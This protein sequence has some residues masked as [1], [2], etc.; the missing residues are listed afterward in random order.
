MLPARGILLQPFILLLFWQISGGALVDFYKSRLSSRAF[1]FLHKDP[2][3][4]HV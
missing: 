3:G 2:R 4:V 1:L